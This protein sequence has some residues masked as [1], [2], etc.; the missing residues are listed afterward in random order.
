MLSLHI[1]FMTSCSIIT[2]RFLTAHKKNTFILQIH[3]AIHFQNNFNTWEIHFALHIRKNKCIFVKCNLHSF[4]SP[5]P[6]ILDIVLQYYIS[7]SLIP[8]YHIKEAAHVL[9]RIFST[10]PEH[11]HL[12]LSFVLLRVHTLHLSRVLSL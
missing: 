3:V 10:A 6:H 8:L 4:E 11:V 1:F 5:L 9:V 12:D 2:R 7:L